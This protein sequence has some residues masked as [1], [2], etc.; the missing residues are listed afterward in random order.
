LSFCPLPNLSFEIFPPFYYE[1]SSLHSTSVLESAA[2]VR[3]CAYWNWVL[4]V[5]IVKSMCLS[6]GV[7]FKSKLQHAGTWLVTA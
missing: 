7:Q 4:S 2:Q 1:T 3:F 6:K 5:G